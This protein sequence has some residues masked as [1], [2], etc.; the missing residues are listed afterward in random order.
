MIE[1]FGYAKTYATV[2]AIAILFSI[3]YLAVC[4]HG[5]IETSQEIG[6]NCEQG[7]ENQPLEPL[8]EDEDEMLLH[9]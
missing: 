3:I 2:G 8:F 7:E 1:P 6:E 4:G 5:Q 9:S